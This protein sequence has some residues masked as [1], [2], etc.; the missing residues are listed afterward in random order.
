MITQHSGAANDAPAVNIGL[1]PSMCRRCQVRRI[2][3]AGPSSAASTSLSAQLAEQ[4]RQEEAT[5]LRLARLIVEAANRWA[6]LSVS[7]HAQDRLLQ[8]LFDWIQDISWLQ[9]LNMR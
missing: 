8:L 9:P 1:L 3:A 7:V 2:A 5:T 6:A 4:Q